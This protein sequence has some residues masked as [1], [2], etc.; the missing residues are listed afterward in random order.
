MLLS[1][2]A[3]S[4]RAQRSAAVSF[5]RVTE[6]PDPQLAP[7]AHFDLRRPGV[8]AELGTCGRWIDWFLQLR[9]R[10]PFGVNEPPQGSGA[11]TGHGLE[12]V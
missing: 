8:P 3:P 6:Q 10:V 2:R 4:T 9:R 5:G 7:F 11:D 1:V 12:N